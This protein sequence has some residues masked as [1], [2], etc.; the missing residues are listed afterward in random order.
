MF[1][2]GAA[3]GVVLWLAISFGFGIYLD[4]FDRRPTALG[5]IFLTWL[6][7]SN[8]ALLFGAEIN[9]VLADIRSRP[10]QPPRSSL[11]EP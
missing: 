7:L 3:I 9:D 10:A 1:T 11:N 8:I 5:I 2:P 6:W 4:T